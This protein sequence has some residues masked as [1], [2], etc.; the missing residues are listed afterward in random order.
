LFYEKPK[1][2]GVG[3]VIVYRLLGGVAVKESS[4]LNARNVVFYL[5]GMILRSELQ[6]GLYGSV[7]GF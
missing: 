7:N 2:S 6:I 5:Q 3:L 1:K 4:D